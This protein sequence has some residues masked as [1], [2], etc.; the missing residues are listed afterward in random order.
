MTGSPPRM[1]GRRHRSEQQQSAV[2]L[3]PAYAG[4]TARSAA[5]RPPRWAHPRVCGEDLRGYGGVSVPLGS[6]PRMRGRRARGVVYCCLGGL[7]PAYAGKTGR[8]SRA[9]WTARAHPRVCGEDVGDLL[10]AGVV[11]GSPPRMRGRLLLRLRP[12]R[13]PRLTPAYAGKTQKGARPMTALTAHPRVCGE[14]RRSSGC[15]AP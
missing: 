9:S 12:V 13:H 14:D 11:A 8:S 4:K 10:V 3:T 15:W 7:T 2:R 6:P 5:S 1:R